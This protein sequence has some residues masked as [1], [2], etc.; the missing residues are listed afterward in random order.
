MKTFLAFFILTLYIQS[1]NTQQEPK[2]KTPEEQ[3]EFNHIKDSIMADVNKT[4]AV[5]LSDTTGIYLAPVKVLEAKIVQEEYS[6]Y[7]NV[8]LR[9]KNVSDKKIS[10]IRF[11]W[12]GL[13]AFG[14]PAD[15]GNSYSSGLGGGFDDDGLGIGKTSS[16]TFSIL[17]RDA[18]K[19]KYAWANEIAFADGTIWTFRK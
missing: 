3:A 9:W 17:S 19:I 7:R 14:E 8:Y 16:G 1:C 5:K 4:V 18:K 13:N 11:S 2:T 15:L 6:N 12:Y 10:S